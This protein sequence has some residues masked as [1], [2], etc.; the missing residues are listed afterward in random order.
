MERIR[1]L[2]ADDHALF[3]DGVASIM[4]G[5]EDIEVAGEVGSGEEALEKTREL[6]PDLILMDINMPG[7]NGL[8]ATRL[9]KKEMPYIKIVMLTVHDE[10]EKVFEAVKSGAQGYLLKNIRSKELLGLVRG[11]AKGEAP[12]SPSVATKI[13]NE[14]ASLAHQAEREPE[15]PPGLTL[16]EREVLQHVATGA[17]NKEIGADLHISENTVKNHLRNIL[18]KLHLKNRT[19]AADYALRRGLIRP[20]G[21]P[22]RS[23]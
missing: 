20:P 5:Q 22:Q 13:L 7:L 9:I 3:R 15:E 2:L 11:V 18:E 19:Q 23:C 4:A 1:V 10:D 6:M 16:R 12:I 17:A 8:E 14:F 21:S